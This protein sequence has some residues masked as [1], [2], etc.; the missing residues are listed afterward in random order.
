MLR[1]TIAALAALSFATVAFAADPVGPF[2]L[3][4]KGACHAANGQFAKKS[5]C[6]AKPAA[7]NHCRD[8]KTKKFEKCSVAGAVP[9]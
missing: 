5:F 6:A 9:A 3:D 1:T 8:P 7:T 4:A 2:K